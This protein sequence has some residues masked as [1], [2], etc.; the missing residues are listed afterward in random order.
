VAFRAD[1]QGQITHLFQGNLPIYGYRKL[2][3]YEPN[4]L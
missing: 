3:W 1:D 2:A 4:A